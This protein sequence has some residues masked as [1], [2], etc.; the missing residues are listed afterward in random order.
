MISIII[1]TYNVNEK[2]IS[3]F[4]ASI[5]LQTVVSEI[6]I[7]D[8]GPQSEK[9]VDT[10]PL[11]GVE[12]MIAIKRNE[13][14]HGRTRNLAARATS[15][16]VLVFLTQDALLF[17]ESC[18]EDLIKPLNE[19]EVAASYGRQIHREEAKPTEK[20]ARLYN[21][22]EKPIIKGREQIEEMGIKT[23]FFS[24]VFSAIRRKEFEEIGGFPENVL[25][26][27]DM[28]FA[29]KLIEGGY[30][31]AYVPEAKVIHSHDYSLLQQLRRYYQAGVSFQRNPWFMCY[32]GSNRE[33]ITFLREETKFL[34]KQNKYLWI[35]YAILEAICKYAG[36][37]LGLNNNKFPHFSRKG[38]I[39]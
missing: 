16:D 19:P 21:Y 28:L 29:A 33:G 13:F 25:M 8:S 36:Y 4:I 39:S 10:G 12:K 3:E 26:F 11:L 30:K 6:I 2:T 14:N 17:N 5:R 27:E 31:I 9:S 22:P 1:P 34:F 7:I 38:A 23:F 18:I 15:G 32:T 35:F 20:F 37:K 24:N